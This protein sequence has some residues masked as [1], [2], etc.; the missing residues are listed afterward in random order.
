MHVRTTIATKVTAEYPLKTNRVWQLQL[1]LRNSCIV[2]VLSVRKN[3]STNNFFLDCIL[4][5]SQWRP[6]SYLA[7]YMLK[8]KSVSRYCGSV[9]SF[10]YFSL[11]QFMAIYYN[12]YTKQITD[13]RINK[14]RF[15]SH[16][17]KSTR[18]T[19]L[20]LSHCNQEMYM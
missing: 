1:G 5:Q 9:F 7:E 6:C 4:K 18:W 2:T 8:Q 17:Q 3:W 14:F 15:F 12:L 11:F 20:K 16:Y 19:M 13:W 10:W